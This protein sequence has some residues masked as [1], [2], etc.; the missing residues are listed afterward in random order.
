MSWDKDSLWRKSVLFLDRAFKEVREGDVFPLW[1]SMGL[2]LLCRAAVANV[3]PLLLAEPEKDQRH[4]LHVLGYGTAN[5]KSVNMTQVLGLCKVLIAKFTDEEVRIAQ[6]LSGR[7]NEELH[8][9]SAAFATFPVQDWLPGFFRTCSILAD[10]LGYTL[11][12]LLGPEEANAANATLGEAE[13]SLV[14]AVKGEIHAHST[15]FLARPEAERAELVEKA[16]VSGDELAHQRHH[17]VECPACKSVATVQ[18][19]DVG[20]Q[21][22]EHGDGSITVR[23]TVLP[24]RF[25]CSACGLRLVGYQALRAAGVA[26]HFTRRSEFSPSEYYELIDPDDSSAM[27]AY[28][29]EYAEQHDYYQ[30][31]ND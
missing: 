31:N 19:D 20:K 4:V 3:S 1:A 5:P 8:T 9:G 29:R 11:G 7:R 16:R 6:S 26:D 15:A 30:F 14:N 18:G 24:T 13:K 10:S 28:M 12:D 27:D 2:E 17:R 22:V 21:Q 23:Q 25:V